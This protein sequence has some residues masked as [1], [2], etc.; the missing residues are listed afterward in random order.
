MKGPEAMAQDRMTTLFF[1]LFS[2]LPRQGP[3]DLTSTLRAL[4]AV[5]AMMPD[6]PHRGGTIIIALFSRTSW[7][8]ESVT[9]RS[10][11]PRSW[12]TKSNVKS[13]CGT[14]VRPTTATC[15]SS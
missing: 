1:E 6:N 12:R 4:A 11:T 7:S 2:G 14:P 5:P 8:S 9:R 13:T 10:P 3:G 15:F